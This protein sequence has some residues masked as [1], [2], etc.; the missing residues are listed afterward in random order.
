MRWLILPAKIYSCPLC[1]I[2]TR[3]NELLDTIFNLN[4]KKMKKYFL[5]GL[6]FL[7]TVNLVKSQVTFTVKPGLNFNGANIGYKSEKMVPYVGLQFLNVNYKYKNNDDPNPDDDNT[8]THVFMPYLGIKFF[9]INKE[10]IKGS[11]NGTIFKPIIFGKETE[12]GEENESYKKDLKELK[13]WGGELGYGM[14]YF[15]DDHFSIGGEFGF[16]FGFYK[17]RYE[18]ESSDYW[19]TEDFYLNM[20][21]ISASMNF[22][23]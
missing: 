15:F 10:S 18:S 3:H 6:L 1:I 20:S 13:L 19:S 8:K 5:F 2:M 16:R 7:I 17:D 23:L 4:L 22:Y 14:E 21:Y 12:N 11:V 9:V